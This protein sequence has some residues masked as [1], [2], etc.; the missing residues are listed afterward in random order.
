MITCQVYLPS[1]FINQK[2]KII[3][4]FYWLIYLKWLYVWNLQ[5]PHVLT[6][7]R[8]LSSLVIHC[9][10]ALNSREWKCLRLSL[11]PFLHRCRSWP[12]NTRPNALS[13]MRVLQLFRTLW[14]ICFFISTRF[15]FSVFQERP[16]SCSDC[17]SHRVYELSFIC[18]WITCH[19]DHK[20]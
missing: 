15:T 8:N 14:L 19:S 10:R 7:W 11:H 9:S 5:I 1:T 6:E 18:K 3:L 20:N 2:I 17:F 16:S 13:L 4:S 12:K